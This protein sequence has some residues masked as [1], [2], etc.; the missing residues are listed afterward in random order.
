MPTYRLIVV[1]GENEGARTIPV[2]QSVI[3]QSPALRAILERSSSEA[4]KAA[5]MDQVG[6]D[7]SYNETP[8]HD[9]YHEDRSPSSGYSKSYT[10]EIP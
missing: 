6:F 2:E 10:R 5:P 3:D 4:L 7:Q 8:K 1:G 9:N